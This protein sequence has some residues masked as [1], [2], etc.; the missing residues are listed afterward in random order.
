[1][2]WDEGF[3]ENA[4]DSCVVN[5]MI[6]G[7]QCTI[8]WH[9]DDLKISHVD[10]KVVDDIIKMLESIYGPM[11]ISRG[12]KHTY[13]GMDFDF[14]EDGICTVSMVN[15]LEE[16]VDDFSVLI[17]GKVSTPAAM[18]LFIISDNPIMLDQKKKRGVSPRGG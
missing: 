6:N 1:M 17:D 7:K 13:L 12:K 15:Y 9:V 11:T 5:K 10:S 18:H 14:S 16:T 3:K 4:Y 2:L 8:T